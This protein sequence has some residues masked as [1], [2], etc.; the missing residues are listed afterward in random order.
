[1]KSVEKQGRTVEEA[2]E[3]ALKELNASREDVEIEVLEEGSKG[4]LGIIGSQ[5][6]RVRVTLK[7]KPPTILKEVLKGIVERMGASV[8]VEEPVEKEGAFYINISGDDAGLIIGRNGATLDAL[9]LL[10]SEIVRKRSDSPVLVWV[11]A[12][13][14]RER[15]WEQV[16]RM[17]LDAMRR[18]KSERREIRLYNLTPAERRIVHLTL[19]NNS[20]IITY[21][22]G[23][24]PN[25]VLVV[26]PVDLGPRKKGRRRQERRRESNKRS[27]GD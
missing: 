19:Q 21:S 25:R 5:Q 4:V 22:E 9:Q 7:R 11:D 26:A 13:R 23:E 27:E 18:A 20:D 12:D 17:A 24:E 16:K 10:V 6:A 15:R 1:M 8:T 14:Y 3:A 2:I